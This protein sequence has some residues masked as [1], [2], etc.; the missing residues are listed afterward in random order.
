MIKLNELEKYNF[1]NNEKL[2]NIKPVSEQ[3]YCN[4]TYILSTSRQKYLIKN[5][6]SNIYVSKNHEFFIQNITH[7][8]SISAKALFLDK[9]SSFMVQEYM[10][11][12]HKF[13]LSKK[14]IKNLACLLSKLHKIKVKTNVF[15]I[16]KYLHSC[17]IDKKLK[18]ALQDLKRYKKDLVLCHNDLNPKNIL[19]TR[20]VKFLDWEY[21]SLNDRY[22]DLA[23][24]CV[25]FR[26]SKNSQ[27][28]FMCYYFK[29][30][31]QNFKKLHTFKILYKYVCYTWQKDRRNPT[32]QE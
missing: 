15:D 10:E 1:F 6:I 8:K 28:D 20:K 24:I 14:D 9:K 19:F 7:R 27:R 32:C 18:L 25:E 30:K 13:K 29:N 2:E 22:F 3:G 4:T 16:N 26:L 31:M 5:T 17:V 21:S 12:I 23:S 11:G